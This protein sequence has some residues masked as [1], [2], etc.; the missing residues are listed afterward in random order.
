MTESSSHN[1]AHWGRPAMPGD[2]HAITAA[3]LTVKGQVSEGEGGVLPLRVVRQRAEAAAVR[4]ALAVTG[5]N[6]SR[7]AELLGVTRPTLY[8]LMQRLAQRAPTK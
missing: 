1:N 7:A 5:G 3:D 6:I 4:E 2:D 8:D